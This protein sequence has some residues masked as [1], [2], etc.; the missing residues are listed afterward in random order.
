M[1][2][3]IS[4]FVTVTAGSLSATELRMT[5]YRI[6]PSRAARWASTHSAATTAQW[7]G[8]LPAASCLTCGV[9]FQPALQ[10]AAHPARIDA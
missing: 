5:S 9:G 10:Q 8:I 4:R 2:T 6:H 1:Q 3:L 7:A